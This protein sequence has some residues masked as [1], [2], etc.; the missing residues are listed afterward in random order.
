V[1]F[2]WFQP[3]ENSL[4][5]SPNSFW[6]WRDSYKESYSLHQILSSPILFQI[7]GARERIFWTSQRL[8]EFE[9]HL[10]R[11][12]IFEPVSNRVETA[13]RH[14]VARACWSAP[15]HHAAPLFSL[16]CTPAA[17]TRPRHHPVPQVSRV[18][19]A[20]LFSPIRATTTPHALDDR[21]PLLAASFTPRCRLL[22][23]GPSLSLSP[24]SRPPCGTEPTP[25]LHFPLSFSPARPLIWR[26]HWGLTLL[27]S[28]SMPKL[29]FPPSP[30]PTHPPR[31]L[32]PPE[33][34]LLW[35]PPKHRRCP[36]S[37]V[38]TTSISLSI[39]I[40]SPPSASPSFPNIAVPRHRR[41]PSPEL[42]RCHWTLPPEASS[43]ASTP[44]RCSGELHTQPPC[45][46]CPPCSMGVDATAAA[47][48]SLLARSHRPRHRTTPEFSRARWPRRARPPRGA[49]R[50]GQ[51]ALASGLS[52]QDEAR[53]AV[54]ALF[55]AGHRPSGL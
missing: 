25:P 49:E 30:P 55:V 1:I 45:P 40:G 29:E 15:H 35:F 52:H 18:T 16:L 43:S 9:F 53:A 46:A 31:G 20:P 37:L 28:A 38:S 36:P 50:A 5:F 24:I 11:L 32:P 27:Y 22:H 10:N 33:T 48:P 44:C 7:F 39:Q 26:S 13:P 51:T 41:H 47:T 42:P 12:N 4:N 17:A 23:M 34:P 21:G 19:H 8:E 14:C 6:I 54:W 3:I 2:P